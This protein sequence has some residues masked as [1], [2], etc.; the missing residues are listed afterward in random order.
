MATNSC[1]NIHTCSLEGHI[2]G[3]IDS[4]QCSVTGTGMCF[5]STETGCSLQMAVP[6]HFS[7]SGL[8]LFIGAF[9]VLQVC[10]GP[11]HFPDASAYPAHLHTP[12]PELSHGSRHPPHVP[13]QLAQCLPLKDPHPVKERK[14]T[15]DLSFQNKEA[16]Y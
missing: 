8:G 3:L 11:Q 1:V 10:P 9:V 15:A 4:S 13:A 5:L 16:F 6:G 7:C 14:H 2:A 12:V